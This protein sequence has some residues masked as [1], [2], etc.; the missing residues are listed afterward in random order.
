MPCGSF[1]YYCLCQNQ[2]SQKSHLTRGSLTI[3]YLH[4]LKSAPLGQQLSLPHSLLLVQNPTAALPRL[5]CS[6]W[7]MG[8]CPFW[9][10]L[11]APCIRGYHLLPSLPCLSAHPSSPPLRAPPFLSLLCRCWGS[12]CSAAGLLP[13]LLQLSPGSHMFSQDILMARGSSLSLHP[14]P[15]FRALHPE[16]QSP[17]GHC[18][19][20]SVP[21]APQNHL[22]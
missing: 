19:Y 12:G 21:Q 10:A 5:L 4:H 7:Q 1:S 3:S 2:T 20:L 17:W 22:V 13:P 9:S 15:L 14:A 6:T 16:T 11:H 8:C 18:S